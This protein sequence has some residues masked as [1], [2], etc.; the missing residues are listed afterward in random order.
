M[1]H[2]RETSH[3]ACRRGV[4]A[5]LA[6]VAAL[7][8]AVAGADYPRLTKQDRALAAQDDLARNLYPAQAQR[9]AKPPPSEE[10]AQGVAVPSARDAVMQ[11]LSR[12]GPV[13]NREL[14]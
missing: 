1:G 6:A 9:T 12:W 10:I 11:W 5:A 4:V 3:R 7:V 2:N 8:P 14:R 13:E